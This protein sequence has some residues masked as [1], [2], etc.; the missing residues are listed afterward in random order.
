MK[1]S[2]P[3]EF[4]KFYGLLK[5]VKDGNQA[6]KEELDW[7]LAEYEHAKDSK[8]AYDELGQIFC[9]IGVMELFQYT[10]I[11]DL[12]YISKLERAVWEYLKVRTGEELKNHLVRKMKAHCN[13]H[14]LILKISKSWD[15]N[16]D[17]LKANVEALAVYV[18]DGI[19]EILI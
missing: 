2:E 1:M 9:H 11:E 14:N 5:T 17:E 10:G 15:F 16:E 3:I 19:V 13:D 12:I 6:K 4:G 8:G 18:T 7:L